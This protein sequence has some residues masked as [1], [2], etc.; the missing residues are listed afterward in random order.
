MLE[1]LTNRTV[2][3]IY[4]EDRET[5]LQGIISNNILKNEPCIYTLILTPQGK[6]LFD[7]FIY[8]RHD[9]MLVD[10]LASTKDDLLKRLKM[11]KLRSKVEIQDLSEIYKVYFADQPVLAQQSYLD[12]RTNSGYRIITEA[13]LEVNDNFYQE[14]RINQV[15]PESETELIC[16]KTF[17]LEYGLDYLNAI[18]FTKGCYVGQEL[19]ARTKHRGVIRKQPFL[20]KAQGVLEPAQEI[21]DEHGNKLG[22]IT[23]SFN[24]KAIGF[25]RLEELAQAQ[26]VLVNGMQIEVIRPEWLK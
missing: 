17:P 25:I 10:C 8:K 4:G 22:Y 7:L 3:G 5:L 9:H 14:F 12:P 18:D 13:S 24:N 2:I 26:Q 6:F 15:L 20:I 21:M 11:Y 16:D 19:T 1:K 23:S